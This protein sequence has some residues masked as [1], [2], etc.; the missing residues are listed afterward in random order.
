MFPFNN[1]GGTMMKL[2][3]TLFATIGLLTAFSVGAWADDRV[4]ETDTMVG[5]HG[6]FV[7][8]ANPIRGVN[9]GGLPWV[10]DEAKVEL[11]RDGK[12]EVEVEGL[13]I[14]ADDGFGFNPAPFF[15]AIV[16][17]LSVDA[18]GNIV[19]A[20]VMTTNDAEVMEG[21]PSNG[22]AKIEED[23]ELPTPCVAPIVFVTSPDGSWFS[24]TGQMSD[25]DP[26]NSSHNTAVTVQSAVGGGS[27]GVGA[28]GLP[29]FLL[30]SLAALLT[31]RQAT[32]MT[33]D[34]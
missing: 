32:A 18:G 26:E 5:V 25:D 13:I 16:S 17:C 27:S 33:T 7:G 34:S 10:L 12:L 22:D 30:L 29:F 28:T 24:A 9:G 4:L 11:E 1:Q 21:D 23:V 20:N 2:L 3:C 6:P 19:V 8:T 31:R 15:R 14:P